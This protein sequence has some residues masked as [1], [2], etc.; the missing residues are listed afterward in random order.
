M[1]ESRTHRIAL[2]SLATHADN[3]IAMSRIISQ[4]PKPL[5]FPDLRNLGALVRILLGTNLVFAAA[6]LVRVDHWQDWPGAWL[7]IV[8]V[9]EP[10]LL[11]QTTLLLLA[12]PWLARLSFRDG[13]GVVLLG[14]IGVGFIVHA[15]I[16]SVVPLSPDSLLRH[17]VLALG[18]T[19]ALLVHFFYRAKALSPAVTEARL[20]ALQARIRPHFLFNSINAVLSMI[21]AEPKQAERALEDLADLFRVLMS[22]NRNLVPLEDEVSLCRQYLALEKLRLGDRLIVEWH[23]NSMPADAHVP[24]LV[25]QPLIENAVYHGIEPLIAPGIVSINIFT[26]DGQVHAILRN[27]YRVEGGRHHGGNKMALGNVKERLALH[28][29]VE[30]TLESQV[31]GDSYEVHIRMPYRRGG[32]PARAEAPAAGHGEGE[33][34]PAGDARRTGSGNGDAPNV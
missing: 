27:P 26:K 33:V 24:P 3:T 30:A 25:L 29:D 5:A 21:R 19:G 15:V 18:V 22:D 13:A 12:S 20:Q 11:L 23:L 34:A 9:G 6:A 14:T 7:D 2:A 16:G 31:K 17:V 10:H 1:P 28:F 32:L 4:N 8:A